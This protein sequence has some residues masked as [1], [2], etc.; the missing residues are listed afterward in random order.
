M[1]SEREANIS[2]AIPTGSEELLESQWE[3]DGMFA[4]AP[5]PPGKSKGCQ[6]KVPTCL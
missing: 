4:V 6:G 1:H 2:L 5:C 3:L